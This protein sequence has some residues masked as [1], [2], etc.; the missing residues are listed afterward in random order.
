MKCIL[1][2]KDMIIQLTKKRFDHLV[3]GSSNNSEQ[4]G[5]KM[6]TTEKII[7]MAKSKKPERHCKIYGNTN[8][9]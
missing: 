9:W 1:L 3:K 7:A 4:K 5:C 8:W 6:H 2:S